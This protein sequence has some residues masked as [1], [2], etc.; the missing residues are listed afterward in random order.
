M[1]RKIDNVG[2]ITIPKEMYNVLGLKNGDSVHIELVNDSIV[3]TNLDRK[4]KKEELKS[5]VKEMMGRTIDDVDFD[6]IVSMIES[7]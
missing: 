5:Y 3:I 4:D 7:L 1:I 2:R 6:K